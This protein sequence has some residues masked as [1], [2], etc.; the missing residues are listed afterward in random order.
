MYTFE[1]LVED[2]K[3]GQ[4]IEFA[5]KGEKYA[6]SRNED[7]FLIRFGD[8]EGQVF[9]G[10]DELLNNARINMKTLKEIWA[11]TTGI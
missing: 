8:E 3:L 2:L 9:Q 7:W 1:N 10:L 6:I 11:E 4:E 5:Y